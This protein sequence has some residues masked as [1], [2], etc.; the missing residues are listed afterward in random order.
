MIVALGTAGA[1]QSR[2][3]DDAALKDAAKTGEE[4][5]SIRRRWSWWTW[6]G[7]SARSQR[8]GS[9]CRTRRGSARP[10]NS[11]DTN[12]SRDRAG[13]PS[14][15]VVAWDPGAKKDRW[16]GLAAGFN[17]GG[18]LST[19][20]NLVFSSVNTRLLA[21]RADT[22]EQVLDG[23]CRCCFFIQSCD[24]TFRRFTMSRRSPLR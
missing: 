14:N 17:Q 11:A 8:G 5:I 23:A 13:R 4:W 9:G 1:Q 24:A 19:A 12:D 16:R 3:V 22:G 20:G 7:A 10:T 2:R 21:Y 15:I 6:S 18:T